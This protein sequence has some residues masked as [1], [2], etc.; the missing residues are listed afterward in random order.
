VGYR[1]GL[2]H[3]WLAVVIMVI[4]ALVT[5]PAAARRGL[6]HA[7][8]HWQGVCS[9]LSR[10]PCTPTFCS[11]FHRAPCTPEIEY[12]I[13]QDLRFT[14]V[15]TAFEEKAGTI[16]KPTAEQTDAQV[17]PKITTIREAF[18]A[19]RACW[20]PPAKNEARDDFIKEKP[21]STWPYGVPALLAC[22]GEAWSLSTLGQS[23]Y[24]PFELCRYDPAPNA[25]ALLRPRNP[26]GPSTV[27]VTGG[28][29]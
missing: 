3:F 26:G 4:G 25:V 28:G 2:L 14:I 13:G 15:S 22:Q 18:N 16:S 20:I 11:V 19:L 8:H 17:R 23:Y 7:H 9:V 10:H 1:K 24:T 5:K 6:L 12:P 29:G 21:H 27:F